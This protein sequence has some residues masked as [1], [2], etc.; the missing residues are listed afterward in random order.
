MNQMVISTYCCCLAA[1][2]MSDFVQPYGL[3]HAR[4]LCPWDPLGKNTRVGYHALLQGIFPTQG[5]N[6]GFLH[7]RQSINH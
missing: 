2:V 6:P 1:T 7:H 5:S 4:L 3:Q